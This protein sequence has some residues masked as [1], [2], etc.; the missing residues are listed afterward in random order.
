MQPVEMSAPAAHLGRRGT[1]YSRRRLDYLAPLG[2]LLG[3]GAIILGQLMEG[4]RLADVLQPTAAIIVFGG[5][6]GAVI[7]TTP[8][9]LLRSALR[10]LRNMPFE[11]EATAAG[12]VESIVALS[13][14]ARKNGIISMEQ[15]VRQIP[16]EFLRRGLMLA[17]DGTAMNTLKEMLEMEIKLEL[18][19]AEMDAK[20]LESAGGYAPT[21]GIV[22]A[23][24]GLIQ[25]MKHLDN[26]SQ[27]G[28]G[29]AVAF[30][31]TI[32][33]VGSAN[34]I[35][36]PLGQKMRL[37]AWK[38]M[39]TKHLVLEGVV[40]IVQG[41]NPRMVRRKLDAFVRRE[42]LAPR[43]PTQFEPPASEIMPS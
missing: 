19:E 33:G 9:S 24:V 16:Y 2:V 17:V 42:G 43:M 5:T 12:I 6:F 41:L 28:A 25:V 31:A 37:R 39:R 14:K 10:R 7:L 4:G 15:E 32:Y 35:F 18:S 3:F 38:A 40:G 26:L 1:D 8:P 36:L 21:I 29:I 20:V 34:L 23:V 22:G 30:V 11:E 27:V 13:V